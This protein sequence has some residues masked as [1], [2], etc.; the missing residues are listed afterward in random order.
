MAVVSRR[1]LVHR[2]GADQGKDVI[3]KVLPPLMLTHCS[4]PRLTLNLNHR[5]CRLLESRRTGSLR[6]GI[7]APCRDPGIFERRLSRLLQSAIGPPP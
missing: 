2:Q 3:R 1:H 4:P 5:V 6:S 7:A